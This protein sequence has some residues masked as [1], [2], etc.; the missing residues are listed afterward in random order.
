MG[1]LALVLRR[2]GPARQRGRDVGVNRFCEREERGSRR[3]TVSMTEL[4]EAREGEVMVGS[5]RGTV[6]STQPRSR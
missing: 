3:L 2:E 1:G 5:R 6:S 4:L